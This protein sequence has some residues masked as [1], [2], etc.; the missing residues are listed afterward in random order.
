MRQAFHG[1]SERS[2]D[3]VFLH[4]G[5]RDGVGHSECVEDGIVGTKWSRGDWLVEGLMGWGRMPSWKCEDGRMD[6]WTSC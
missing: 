6:G 1:K 3:K 2:M 4:A 5:V